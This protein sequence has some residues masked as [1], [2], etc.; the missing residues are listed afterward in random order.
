MKEEYYL[1]EPRNI[2]RALY[3]CGLSEDELGYIVGRFPDDHHRW[4]GQMRGQVWLYHD[5]VQLRHHFTKKKLWESTI[6][7]EY[8]W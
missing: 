7:D 5:K 1:S 6:E 3:D 8:G 4:P 2:E